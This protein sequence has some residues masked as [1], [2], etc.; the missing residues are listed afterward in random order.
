MVGL[1]PLSLSI[2]IQPHLSIQCTNVL[3]KLW[4]VSGFHRPFVHAFTLE[5]VKVIYHLFW[6]SDLLLDSVRANHFQGTS[7]LALCHRILIFGLNVVIFD[8]FWQ[9]KS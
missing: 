7:K 1:L 5:Y 4:L 2:S 9:P 3:L 6:L 8:E